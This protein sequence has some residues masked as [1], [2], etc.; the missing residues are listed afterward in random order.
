MNSLKITKDILDVAAIINSVKT[1]E[2]GAISVF[3]GTTR[4]NCFGKK[5]KNL[6]YE[7][8]ETMALKQMK[9]IAVHTKE[10]WP[11]VANIAIHHR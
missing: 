8:Y 7:A 3:I 6:Y 10:K 5:V 4:D 11:D 9:S 1:K 2:C